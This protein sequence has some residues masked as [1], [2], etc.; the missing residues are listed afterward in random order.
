MKSALFYA[1]GAGVFAAL[2]GIFPSDLSAQSQSF[3]TAGTHSFT[4]PQG[5]LSL[6]VECVGGGGAGGRVTPS[7]IFDSDASGGGGGG[8]YASALVPVVQGNIYPLTVGIGGIN[9]GS[10]TDGG[11]S[12][13]DA[14][15][16]VLAKGGSTRSGNDNESG[17][18]GGQASASAGSI[19]Y[20]GGNG[21]DGD[22]GDADGGGGGGAAGSTGNGYSGNG[23]LGGGNRAD[24]GG[25][26]GAGGGNGA[27][28]A[29]GNAY[30]GGG[31]GSSAN[32]S[33][34]RDGGAG[35][36]G[37][38]VVSWTEIS[39]FAP[40]QVCQSGNTQ[41]T[42]SGSHFTGTDSVTINGLFIPFTI[43]GDTL[44][45]LTLPAGTTSGPIVVST[46]YGK[47][48]HAQPL[49]IVSNSVTV[50]ASGNQLTA[51]YSGGAQASY[52]WLDCVQNNAPVS[53][54]VMP[55]YTATQN[56][57]FAVQVTEN[58]CTVTSECFTVSNT[59]IETAGKTVPD[60]NIYPNPC[61]GTLYIVAEHVNMNRLRVLDITGKP[62][63]QQ[64]VP[65]PVHSIDLSGLQ[66]GIYLLELHSDAGLFT[67]RII[68]SR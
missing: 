10:S 3:T 52:Q 19:K 38:V 28:G 15:L 41:I 23:L 34:D 4:V 20:N 6:K 39:G 36:S 64:N 37:I 55:V 65:A 25:A 16:E 21:G 56:G 14:G 62:L 54:A 48:T 29:A 44:L 42:V 66:P 8:A 26:G 46:P 27:H 63:L 30:G 7:N 51:V 57:L 59:G 31:G 18:Q 9:D 17:A 33:N 61:T 35:A 49:T 67:R 68:L 24:Y 53:G 40:Q 32:G 12:F 58:G 2:A 5:V 50:S 22:E 45:V 60:F 43:S 11:D 13:F 47:S 1:A